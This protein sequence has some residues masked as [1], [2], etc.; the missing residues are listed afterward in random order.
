MATTTG[1]DSVCRCV[2]RDSKGFKE[3]QRGSEKLRE[4]QRGARGLSKRGSKWLRGKQGA[5]RAPK[6]AKRGSEG[7]NGVQRV[8]AGF[9]GAQRGSEGLAGAQRGSRGLEG[10]R[11]GSEGLLAVGVHVWA[12]LARGCAQSSPRALQNVHARSRSWVVAAAERRP[13][14]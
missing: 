7:L 1:S 2:A 12:S 13:S 5:S 6:E 10:V 14:H 8:S 3:A 4:A 9:R 11:R